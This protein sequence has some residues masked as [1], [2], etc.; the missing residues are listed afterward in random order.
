MFTTLALAVALAAPVPKQTGAELK[1]KFAKGDT[2]Y[3]V[4]EHEAKMTVNLGGAGQNV[5]TSSS[6]TYKVTVKDDDPKAAVLEVEFVSIAAKVDGGGAAPPAKQEDLAGKTLTFTLDADH[7]ATKV[8]GAEEVVK[9]AGGGG[10]NGF[11]QGADAMKHFLDDLVRA[12]P[13]KSLGKGDTWTTELLQALGE[14]VSMARTEKGAFAGGEGGLTKLTAD[15]DRVMEWTGN[16]PISLKMKGEKG[17]R[18]VLFDP[19]ARRVRR[20]ADEYTMAGDGT[21]GGGGGGQA[22]SM[23]MEVKATITVSDDKPKGK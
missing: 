5:T 21:V 9:A 18:T 4:S 22:I 20:V 7:K 16:T 13:G 1:W 6:L 8:D 14:G 19:K 2:F 17:K 15:V 3:V 11:F 12:V 10:L 23:S